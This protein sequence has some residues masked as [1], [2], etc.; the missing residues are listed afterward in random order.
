MTLNAIVLQWYLV[1]ILDCCQ[2][3]SDGIGIGFGIGICL[4]IDI[5]F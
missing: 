4:S 3:D 1:E 5:C 2:L